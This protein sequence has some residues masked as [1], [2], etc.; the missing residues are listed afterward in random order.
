[1]REGERRGV[2][3]A[4][5][6]SWLRRSTESAANLGLVRPDLTTEIP[7]SSSKFPESTAASCTKHRLHAAPKAANDDSES[8]MIALAFL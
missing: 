3:L 8:T 7:E 6:Y 4:G 5:S 2:A 1:M